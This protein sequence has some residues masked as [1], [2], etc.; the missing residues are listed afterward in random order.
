VLMRPQA[1]SVWAW[2]LAIGTA[3]LTLRTKINPVWLIAV[4]AGV[5]AFGGV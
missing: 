2:M 4:G 3:A 1:G 5:G